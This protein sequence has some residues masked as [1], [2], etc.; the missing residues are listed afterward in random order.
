M[1]WCFAIINNK[2]AELYF[3][4]K[5]KHIKFIGHAFIKTSE[6]TTKAEQKAIAKD[7]KIHRFVY[8][9]KKYRRV[10]TNQ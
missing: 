3:E 6:Y 8:R 10:S 4:K 1:N 2:L 5:N 7:I 9:N